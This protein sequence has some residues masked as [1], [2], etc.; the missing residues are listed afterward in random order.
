MIDVN[1]ILIMFHPFT[2]TEYIIN[3]VTRM[4]NVNHIIIIWLTWLTHAQRNSATYV[5]TLV[6]YIKSVEHIKEFVMY[7]NYRNLIDIFREYLE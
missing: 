6:T 7:I 3:N 5:R 4:I 2:F 1:Y